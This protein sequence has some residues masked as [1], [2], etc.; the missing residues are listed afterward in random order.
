MY[1]NTNMSFIQKLS[2]PI[3]LATL[4]NSFHCVSQIS[5]QNTIIT[6]EKADSL[7]NTFDEILD[8]Q[9]KKIDTV[10][11]QQLSQVT[12]QLLV[13][14]SA[15]HTDLL[16]IRSELGQTEAIIK[17]SELYLAIQAD[18]IST[19]SIVDLKKSIRKRAYISM[20]IGL[21]SSALFFIGNNGG[22]G[23]STKNI[24]GVVSL[25]IPIISLLS[26]NKQLKS[27]KVVPTYDKEL[28]KNQGILADVHSINFN[29]NYVKAEI[30]A[31]KKLIGNIDNSNAAN[32]LKL[33]NAT[34]DTALK[35]CAATSIEITDQLTYTNHQIAK[36][37]L[38]IKDHQYL[39]GFD[40]SALSKLKVL[41]KQLDQFSENWENYKVILNSINMKINAFTLSGSPY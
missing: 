14:S 25:S 6:F 21:A 18:E 3:V 34:T 33:K 4:L 8:T 10:S 36:L 28:F 13:E 23:K 31:L 39:I 38:L 20:G 5:S 41:E 35:H 40:Q 2:I 15:I 37:N 32:Q 16:S 30:N 26:M 7:I 11:Y 29:K 19:N 9:T 1:F 27:I 12:H 24:G 22:G 17:A